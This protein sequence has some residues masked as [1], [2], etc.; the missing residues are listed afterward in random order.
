MANFNHVKTDTE[1]SKAITH[2]FLGHA[3]TFHRQL[4]DFL[5]ILLDPPKPALQNIW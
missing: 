2:E 1:L 5:L 4:L 3:N